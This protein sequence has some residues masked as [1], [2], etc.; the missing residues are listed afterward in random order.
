MTERSVD[1]AAKYRPSPLQRDVEAIIGWHTAR[2]SL[3]VAP[4]LIGLFWLL[5]G[6]DGALAAAIGVAIVA[7][8]FVLAG[9]VLSKAAR[10]SLGLYHAAALIGFVVRLGLIT[11]AMLLIANVFDVD[12]VAMGISAVIA[13]FALLT[14]ET[15]AVA[16]GAERE[17][18]W[19]S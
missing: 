15:V 8:N 4:A 19:S 14:W 2:R 5:R 16:K 9:F 13:Y 7:G 1:P 18:E 11:L 12:R 6:G 10:I 17:L 3:F